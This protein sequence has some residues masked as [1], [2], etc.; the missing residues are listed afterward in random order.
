[1]GLGFA[2]WFRYLR[3]DWFESGCLFIH[4]LLN[5]FQNPSGNCFQNRTP[6]VYH[7]NISRYFK[8]MFCS[9]RVVSVGYDIVTVDI[10]LSGKGMKVVQ[11]SQ[12]FRIW[13]NVQTSQNSSGYGNDR[14]IPIPRYTYEFS[15]EIAKLS[16][17][18]MKVLQNSQ[19]VSS[20]V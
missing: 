4:K 18:S 20:R 19:N 7:M 5:M 16:G 2:R 14:Y 13:Y 17:K 12:H 9:V 15:T 3:S 10:E 1:M 11:N 8:A 6:R